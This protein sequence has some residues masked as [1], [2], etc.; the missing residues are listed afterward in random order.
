MS[1]NDPDPSKNYDFQ[2]ARYGPCDIIIPIPNVLTLL[3]KEVLNPFY[4]F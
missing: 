3:V 2:H 4:L 1:P